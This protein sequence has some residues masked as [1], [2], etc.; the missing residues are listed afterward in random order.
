[1]RR[2]VSTF[3]A[4]RRDFNPRTP[5]GCDHH[6]GDGL[7]VGV[8][9]IH[10]PQWGA[11]HTAAQPF[12]LRHISIHAP[13]WGATI[14][15]GLLQQS[16]INFNP[17]TPVG[18]D[19]L[20]YAS[21]ICQNVFQSTHPSGV[22]QHLISHLR[23]LLDISIHAPQWGATFALPRRG[24][25]HVF[26]STHPS[27][28]R[29]ISRSSS[30]SSRE[31]QST[32]PS[33]VRLVWSLPGISRCRFQSTHPSGVR[34][35]IEGVDVC[36]VEISIH[37]PQWG[38]T[39]GQQQLPRVRR[40]SIHAPQWGATIP[41]C[42]NSLLPVDFNPRTPVGCDVALVKTVHL[43]DAIS[44]HAPQWGATQLL[45]PRRLGGRFQSTHPSGV[46]LPGLRLRRGAWNFNPRTPVGPDVYLEVQHP[47]WSCNSNSS[48]ANASAG[49]R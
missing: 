16:G 19:P 27:G 13:Q 20:T 42:G 6:V 15:G 36:W 3:T 44:I 46:R 28:V 5:V 49:V 48:S 38:A 39:T 7:L 22:R 2:P 14:L 25:F 32:H 23:F 21:C 40:I 47:C 43:L 8:I 35:S 24:L 31:F 29:L 1:M 30:R 26:Q 45:V 17:R 11:T 4:R 37:A 9:S 10:A 12:A 41:R 18:C 33:G 34:Q